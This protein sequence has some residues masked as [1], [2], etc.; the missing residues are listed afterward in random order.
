[1]RRRL[2]NLRQSPDVT[3][4][5]SREVAPLIWS[6]WALAD[7]ALALEFAR[8]FRS[9]LVKLYASNPEECYLVFYSGRTPSAFVP[10]P[11]LNGKDFADFAD[12]EARLIADGVTR[13][14]ATP[15]E[16]EISDARS[17]HVARLQ[18]AV[19]PIWCRPWTTSIRR[20]STT[21]RPAR[22]SPAC[23]M[24]RCPCRIGRAARCCATCSGRAEDPAA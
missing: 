4:L 6:Y 1:M 22:R 20:I 19:I 21:A 14:T 16:S 8:S 9:Y 11:V 12:I 18:G 23:W 13:K 15:S 7:D 2:R 24:R 17:G 10:S 3:P 5:P